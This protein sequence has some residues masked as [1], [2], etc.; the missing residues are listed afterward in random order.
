MC[1]VLQA[2]PHPNEPGYHQSLPDVYRHQTSFGFEYCLFRMSIDV[3]DNTT[4]CAMYEE[5]T[6]TTVMLRDVTIRNPVVEE[7]S[8]CLANDYGYHSIAKERVDGKCVELGRG[9]SG[10]HTV[11]DRI[12]S[13]LNP[14]SHSLLAPRVARE[15][16]PGLCLCRCS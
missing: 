6:L 11:R 15:I 7:M 2:L 14:K 3:K 16:E 9:M 5:E 8:E 13:G 4:L 12:D 1:V 10:R